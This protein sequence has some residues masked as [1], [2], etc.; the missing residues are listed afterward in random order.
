MEDVSLDGMSLLNIHADKEGEAW[1][2]KHAAEL[3]SALRAHTDDLGA[4][5]AHGDGQEYSL[6]MD[7]DGV[8]LLF[9]WDCA[10]QRLCLNLVNIHQ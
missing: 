9:L 10:T 7:I 4:L 1:A 2:R 8:P 6:K 3:C 5:I